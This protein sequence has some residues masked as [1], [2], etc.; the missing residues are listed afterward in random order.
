MQ[1]NKCEQ[2]KLLYLYLKL[3]LDVLKVNRKTPKLELTKGSSGK[4]QVSYNKTGSGDRQKPCVS[5]FSYCALMHA[6]V[7][8]RL[9]I[10][11]VFSIL[12]RFTGGAELHY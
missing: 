3:P 8:D 2:I 9:H 12:F 4:A 7:Q 6:V 11:Y 10:M 5:I 1:I